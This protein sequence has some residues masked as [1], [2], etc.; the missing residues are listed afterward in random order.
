MSNCVAFHTQIASI[1][2]VLAN[3]AVAEICQVVDDGYAVLRLEMS[4]YQKENKALKRRLQMMERQTVRR[5]AERT[6][7]RASVLNA[8]LGDG[9]QVSRKFRG[10][11]RV[12]GHF[13]VVDRVLN[14]SLERDN[15]PIVVDEDYAPAHHAAKRDELPSSGMGTDIMCGG[16]EEG[17]TEPLHVKEERLK[18]TMENHSPQR[19]LRNREDKMESSPGDDGRPF[20]MDTDTTPAKQ[21]ELTDQQ[22]T[23]RRIWEVSGVQSCIK[24]DS[25]K[26]SVKALQ[27]TG[28]DHRTGRLSSLDSEFAVFE[29]PGQ[30]GTYC[31][32]GSASAETEDPCCSY[33]TETNSDSLQVHSEMQPFPGAEEGAGNSLSSLGSLDWKPDIVVVDS[34]PIKMEAEMRPAWNEGPNGGGRQGTGAKVP[35]LRHR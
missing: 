27:H 13:P 33:S 4:Q 2:E 22:Q 10:T 9:E 29:R 25:E 11:T 32:E 20:S 12:E 30:L 7:A 3:A 16:V 8:R 14:T 6:G 17:R 35:H 5:Y 24:A 21:E 1:M 34:A 19:E 23:R 18:E 28:P 26:E 15:L 31:A